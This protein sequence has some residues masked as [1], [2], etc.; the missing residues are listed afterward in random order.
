MN[1]SEPAAT[2]T[3]KPA[4]TPGTPLAAPP[5]FPAPGKD[6][7]PAAGGL[8]PEIRLFNRDL[9]WLEFNRRVLAQ[10]TDPRTPLLTRVKFLAIFT[11]NLDEFFMKRVGYI[12][13]QIEKGVN[14]AT[15]DGLTPRQLLFA[16][17]SLVC[18]LIAQ[19][20][21]CFEGDIQPALAARGIHVL[22]YDQ[23]TAPERRSVDRW[24]NANVFPILTPLA[25]DP[26]HRFPFIS[27]LSENIGVTVQ[28]PGGGESHF[29]RVKIPD[30]LPRLIAVSVEGWSGAAHPTVPRTASPQDPVRLISLEE[31]IRNN[32]DDLFPGMKV[33]DVMAFRVTR[34]AAIEV[35]EDDHEDML[36]SVENELR[37]RRFARAVRLEGGLNAPRSI[38]DLVASSLRLEPEDVFERG[39]LR[40]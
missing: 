36:Q 6:A 14:T 17:R 16:L 11:S 20:A 31:V 3:V 28:A 23:L 4:A 7:E 10:A 21:A 19:Q 27:N 32:L 37:M 25:V 13:R 8:S 26:G 1:P 30:V 39:G 12:R 33:Q 29:A 38:L 35:E 22:R 34:N 9:S 24:Y 15:P 2:S 5:V 40:E 18:E